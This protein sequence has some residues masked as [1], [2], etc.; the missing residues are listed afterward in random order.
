M[1]FIDANWV[2]L[3]SVLT[4]IAN[5][6]WQKRLRKILSWADRQLWYDLASGVSMF[7]V[8]VLGFSVF[9]SQLV[10]QLEKG[11]R[12]IVGLAAAAALWA[13]LDYRPHPA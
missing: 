5:V 4:G 13:L 9:S 1:S 3:G 2:D 6:M 12:I 11:N 10:E 7:P 8:L